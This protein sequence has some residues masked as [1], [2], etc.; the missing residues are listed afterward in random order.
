MA[1]SRFLF[2]LGFLTQMIVGVATRIVPVF[3]GAPPWS[4]T[5]RDA[6]FGLLNAAVA[7]PALEVA[8]ESGGDAAWPSIAR[9]AG[10]RG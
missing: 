9:T 5:A 3:T 6:T 2:T 8:V 7:A 10:A 1:A 4:R